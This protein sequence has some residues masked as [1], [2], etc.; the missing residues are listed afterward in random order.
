M[1]PPPPDQWPSLWRPANKK[2]KVRVWMF[3]CKCC[4]NFHLPALAQQPALHRP[5]VSIITRVHA[6][7]RPKYHSKT[8]WSSSSTTDNFILSA[9]ATA[10]AWHLQQQPF[11]WRKYRATTGTAL[12]Q[13][14]L[15]TSPFALL[16]TRS[17]PGFISC[18]ND[19]MI[20]SDW[21]NH[22]E[23]WV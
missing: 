14:L 20:F 17:P 18:L 7:H 12:L 10:T 6:P 21:R 9:S 1:H 22:L 3:H 23:Y 15:C 16:A 4:L 19:L 2:T 13:K 5:S 11:L 8:S